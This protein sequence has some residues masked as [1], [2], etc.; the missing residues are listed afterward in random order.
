MW[1]NLEKASQLAQ[2]G[3]LLLDFPQREEKKRE[4]KTSQDKKRLA[5]RGE[6]RDQ[7]EKSSEGVL[8]N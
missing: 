3:L 4:E 2:K 6:R 8:D 7:S 5:T 1:T